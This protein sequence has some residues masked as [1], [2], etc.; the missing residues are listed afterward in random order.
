MSLIKGGLR[1]FFPLTRIPSR[2]LYCSLVS[3][4][5]KPDLQLGVMASNPSLVSRP[6][7]PP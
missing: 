3:F 2:M 1:F 6:P 5:P 7:E 4:Q